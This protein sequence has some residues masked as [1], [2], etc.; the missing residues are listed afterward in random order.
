MQRERKRE[1]EREEKEKEEEEEEAVVSPSE[2]TLYTHIWPLKPFVCG[3]TA[4]TL[5]FYPAFRS[6]RPP[7]ENNG[8]RRLGEYIREC[9]EEGEGSP[10]K[11]LSAHFAPPYLK[12]PPATYQPSYHLLFSSF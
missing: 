7:P 2:L 11:G 10:M 5:P 6:A 12:F 4:I 9:Q 3:S 1:R 8:C